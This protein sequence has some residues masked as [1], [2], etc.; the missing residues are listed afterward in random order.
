VFNHSTAQDLGAE[1]NSGHRSV[2]R[3]AGVNGWP[4][5]TTNYDCF[6]ETAAAQ[7]GYAVKLK[8]PSSSARAGQLAPAPGTLTLV[9]IHGTAEDY[10]TVRSTVSDLSRLALILDQLS[11]TPAPRRL[12]LIGYSGRDFDLFPYAA[13]LAESA[14][15]LWV[16]PQLGEDHRARSL[17]R[18][19]AFKGPWDVLATAL[20]PGR[21]PN[22][23]GF[24]CLAGCG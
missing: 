11:F 9:K 21:P 2:A 8:V 5:I 10:K 18:A 20:T 3:L 14:D 4:V 12:L 19:T 24:R 23:A 1:P 15:V 17:V 22:A 6:P 7:S 13:R 16:D